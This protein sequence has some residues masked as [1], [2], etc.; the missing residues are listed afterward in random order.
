[1]NLIERYEQDL[2]Q[3]VDAG[4][5]TEETK[6]TTMYGPSVVLEALVATLPVGVLEAFVREWGAT[7]N[8][9][10]IIRRLKELA[11]ERK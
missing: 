6:H 9:G 3:R 7:G 10:H 8:Y 11:R 1:M 4:G 2:Q 5:I